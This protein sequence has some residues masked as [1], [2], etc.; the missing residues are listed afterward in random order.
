MMPCPNSFC[1]HVLF[2]ILYHLSFNNSPCFSAKTIAQ[3]KR[4]SKERQKTRMR[5]IEKHRSSRRVFIWTWHSVNW[6]LFSVAMKADSQLLLALSHGPIP[7]QVHL[8][9]VVHLQ[10]QSVVPRSQT[11]RSRVDLAV[12]GRLQI[13][14]EKW[15][16]ANLYYKILANRQHGC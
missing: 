1:S 15:H 13:Q 5:V 11:T 6:L 8:H 9:S 7:V 3:A 16:R 14:P 12:K 10:P 4:Q 2:T